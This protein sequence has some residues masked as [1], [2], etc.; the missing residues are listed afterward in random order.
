MTAWLRGLGA[1]LRARLALRPDT[2]HEQAIVRLIVSAAIGA[3]ILPDGLAVFEWGALE[4]HY[5]V[6]TSYF[7]FSAAILVIGISGAT[8]TFSLMDRLVLRA[9]PYPD[10][11]TLVSL[12]Q[13]NATTGDRLE[14]VAPGNFVDWRARAT[15]FEG[16]A[17]AEP[18]SVDFLVD[19]RPENLFGSRVTERFFDLLRITPIHGR[20]FT[21][22]DHRPGA[23]AA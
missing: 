20:L 3:Y 8:A 17:A 11:A 19:G 21:D 14:E 23:P 4:F 15:T 18:W 9:L 2:E 10:P 12:W 13:R 16:I 7:L 6:F 5:F 1:N 22:A